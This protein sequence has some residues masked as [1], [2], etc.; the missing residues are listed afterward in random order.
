MASQSSLVPTAG[1][2][3]ALVIYVRFRDD[4]GPSREWPVTLTSPPAF[5]DD[6]IAPT[7]NPASFPPESVTRFYHDQ[8]DPTNPLIIYGDTYPEVVVSDHDEFHYY[9]RDADGNLQESGYGVLTQEVL[10]EVDPDVDFTQYDRNGDGEIDYVIIVVRANPEGFCYDPRPSCPTTTNRPGAAATFSG[11]SSLQAESG[12][13]FDT[14]WPAGQPPVLE[15]DGVR[16][17][18]REGS[19]IFNQRAGNVIP[20]KYHQGLWAHE[21]GHDL[22]GPHLSAITSNDVPAGPPGNPAPTRRAGYALMPGAGGAVPVYSYRII[23]PYERVRM[24]WLS[25]PPLTA[26]ATVT[27]G[28]LATTGDCRSFTVQPGGD[29]RTIFIANYQR[30]TFYTELDCFCEGDPDFQ[31]GDVC[32]AFYAE[33][34]LLATGLLPSMI[35]DGNGQYDR[36]DDYDEL[37]ADNTLI[38]GITSEDAFGDLYSEETKTQITPWT[39]PNTSGFTL[40]P[41]AYTPADVAWQA[42]DRVRYASGSSGPIRFDFVQDFR[43]APTLRADSWIGDETGTLTVPGSFTVTDGAT[44]HV[45]AA[46]TLQDAFTVEGGSLVTIEAE[47]GGPTEHRIS[48]RGASRL[49]DGSPTGRNEVVTGNATLLTFGGGQGNPTLELGDYARV[50]SSGL[51]LFASNLDVIR[52]GDCAEVMADGGTIVNNT[53]FEFRT[54][55]SCTIARNDGTFE[56]GAAAA[57]AYDDGAFVA[58]QAGGAYVLGAG[59]LLDVRATASAARVDPGTAF[60]LASDAQIR[61]ANADAW[62]GTS[63]EPVRIEGGTLEVTGSPFALGDLDLDGA[64][65]HVTGTA[66]VEHYTTSG[67]LVLGPGFR[68]DQGARYRGSAGGVPQGAAALIAAR[69]ERAWLEE[70]RVLS[71]RNSGLDIAAS[72]PVATSTRAEQATAVTAGAASAVQRAREANPVDGVGASAFALEAYPNPFNPVAEVTYTLPTA[73]EVFLVVYDV[74]GREV[75]RL[76][77]GLRP[78][79]RHRARFD[80]SQLA[81]GTYVVRLQAGTHVAAHTIVLMK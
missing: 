20:H 21:I 5:A 34:G 48:A 11:V 53:D 51:V 27:L 6:L 23:S 22:W 72:D 60:T 7:P 15:F 44:A 25:C 68:V 46:L 29:E 40:Y 28:S 69:P 67:S 65:L 50:I 3:R 61:L 45:A 55:C 31:C 74:T 52:M 57:V 36:E 66:D 32:S 49:G 81:S 1:Q 63:A 43:Q 76:A 42:I 18:W 35:D 59:A 77:E 54:T 2:S 56:L 26:D 10:E 79:G 9:Q 13:I 33:D 30:D 47:D 12:T 64:A 16:L 75:S 41:A 39:R 58:N 4:I 8:S 17:N 38:N 24:G 71:E 80:G 62:T 73:A 70:E 37:V 19:Y 14:R 78:A